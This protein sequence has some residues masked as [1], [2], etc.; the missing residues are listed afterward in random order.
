MCVRCSQLLTM[1][2]IKFNY[3][4]IHRAVCTLQINVYAS[5]VNILYG[6]GAH[7]VNGQPPHTQCIM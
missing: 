1:S 7:I 3:S 4:E 2:N 5:I 6:G